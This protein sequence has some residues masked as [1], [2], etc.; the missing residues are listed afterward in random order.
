M[1]TVT[2]LVSDFKKHKKS[3]IAALDDR[4]TAIS[5][6]E[7]RINAIEDDLEGEIRE[8]VNYEVSVIEC[9]LEKEYR[10]KSRNLREEIRTMKESHYI[11]YCS[12]IIGIIIF[13][14]GTMATSKPWQKDAIAFFKGLF[15]IF[16]GMVVVP[17]K[18]GKFFGRTMFEEASSPIGYWIVGIIVMLI[19]YGLILFVIA[20][21]LWFLIENFSECLCDDITVVVLIVIN[22]I[23]LFFASLLVETPINLLLMPVI[24][25]TVYTI[26]RFLIAWDNREQKKYNLGLVLTTIAS[27]LLIF[28]LLKLVSC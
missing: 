15:V 16:K 25:F 3:V 17:F 14:L 7:D 22:G 24:A 19:L 4:E 18:I 26:I 12:S 28:G 9:R 1:R 13:S 11:G 21:S 20:R 8:R 23:P 5:K 27:A 2:T 10:V 6:K